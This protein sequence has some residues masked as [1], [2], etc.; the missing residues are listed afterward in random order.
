MKQK[1]NLINWSWL[2]SLLLFVFAISAMVPVSF[3]QPKVADAWDLCSGITITVEVFD[4]TAGAVIGNYY[5]ADE[6]AYE[7]DIP[8]N[9]V[10]RYTFDTEGTPSFTAG[11]YYSSGSYYHNEHTYYPNPTPGMSGVWTAPAITQ[12]AVF[13]ADV[14]ENFCSANP[15]FYGGDSARVDLLINVTGGGPPSPT[16]RTSTS[17]LAV[18]T[19]PSVS[20]LGRRV[21]DTGAFTSSVNVGVGDSVDLSWS[22]NSVNNG[23]SCTATTIDGNP[24]VSPSG[25]SGPKNGPGGGTQVVGSFPAEGFVTFGILCSGYGGAST[26]TQ[27]VTVSV[28]PMADFTCSTTGGNPE[29]LVRGGS[30]IDQTQIQPRVYNGLPFIPYDNDVVVSGSISPSVSNPPTL[31]ISPS[32]P[33]DISANQ[34]YNFIDTISTDVNTTLGSYTITYIATDVVTGQVRSCGSQ[35][36]TVT[37]DTPPQALQPPTNVQID[38]SVCGEMAVTWT[39][40]PPADPSPTYKIYRR[41]D[42]GAFTPGDLVGTAV[43]SP[44]YNRQS[45]DPTLQL[46][47]L[48]YY[49]VSAVYGVGQEST[50]APAGNDPK[51]VNSCS[52]SLNGSYKKLVGAGST[53]PSMSGLWCNGPSGGYILPNGQVFESGDTVY[54][55]ICASARDSEIDLTNVQVEEPDSG[56]SNLENIQYVSSAG[57]KTPCVDSSQPGLVTIGTLA[58]GEVCGF[59]IKATISNPGGPASSLHYFVDWANI[60]TNQLSLAIHSA[61]TNFVIS[62]D[63]P[64]RTETP[65]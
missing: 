3:S 45:T 21:G 17:N 30:R 34:V 61:A 55:E 4:V 11:R 8:Y 38:N 51:V 64:T 56:T 54:F 52:A 31:T 26:T 46:N 29:T 20:L 58:A 24:P 10:I 18:V 1:Q 59:L 60:V 23:N 33:T 14:H 7:I 41:T 65:R 39:N 15:P 36:L 9:H 13:F 22:T 63:E 28:G 48:Y 49:G 37:F 5:A 62:S 53:P 27:Y 35:P 43:N 16:I 32:G 40:P 2:R 25:W 57:G 12:D 42:N 6:A 44:F 47:V 50:I 19:A